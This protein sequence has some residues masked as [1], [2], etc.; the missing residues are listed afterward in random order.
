MQEIS[1]GKNEAGQRLDKL[2]GKF[3]N[4]APKSFIYKM[5]RKK[6]IKLNG[7]KAL[8]KEL[9]SEGDRIQLY[10]SDETIAGFRACAA[11]DPVFRQ[12]AAVRPLSA[13]QIIYEDADIMLI[14]K[15]PG[16]LSQKAKPSDISIN[17]QLVAYCEN[18]KGDL[19]LF[20]P[21]VCNRLDRNT[22]G[23]LLCGVSLAG[24]QYLS[25]ILKN[26][27]LDKYYVT[28]VKGCIRQPMTIHG[29]LL[30]D[31]KRNRVQVVSD[32]K[33]AAAACDRRQAD[34][35]S[36]ETAYEP[37]MSNE[38]YTL[39]RVKLVTGKTHQIRAHLASIGHPVIGDYKYG[40]RSLNDRLKRYGL[41]YQLL[42]ACE[43]H[44]PEDGSSWSGKCFTAEKPDLFLRLERLL[45]DENRAMI[46][47]R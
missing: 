7:G 34:G 42:H 1:V 16:Q 17:E 38:A 25:K 28:I 13:S 26:R 27:T 18:K 47:L 2:L 4:T 21:S 46:F 37:V 41:Q 20:Q 19:G 8:G 29:Y 6:N 14:N 9:L 10:L 5:L 43:V 32:I 35:S 45:L 12:N 36:I 23:I 3:L 33:D 11:T 22:S 44:F 40:D 15:K 24:S 30:K 31:E 39:L